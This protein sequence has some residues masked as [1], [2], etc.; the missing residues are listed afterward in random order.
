MCVVCINYENVHF[1]NKL[2]NRKR[3]HKRIV[4]FLSMSSLSK[5]SITFVFKPGIFFNIFGY[6]V[7]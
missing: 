1:F 3:F 4:F 7:A 2:Q 6:D 5:L